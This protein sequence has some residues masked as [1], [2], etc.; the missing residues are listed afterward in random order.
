MTVK[1][2]L[3]VVDAP[4]EAASSAATSM[5]DAL[6]AMIKTAI[7]AGN[8]DAIQ[9]LVALQ[10]EQ[11][12]ISREHDENDR[13]EQR[14]IAFVQAL[15][16]AQSKFKVI[17]KDTAVEFDGR[18]STVQFDYDS[19]E[20]IAGAIGDALREEGFVLSFEPEVQ[21]VAGNAKISVTA[22]LEHA[23]G[24][25]RRIALPG[26]P[27]AKLMGNQMVFGAITALKRQLTR[28]ITGATLGSKSEELK[29]NE[30]RKKN[31]QAGSY[32]AIDRAD[33]IS[34]DQ[35][36]DL[37]LLLKNSKTPETLFL[38]K[39]KKRDWRDIAKNEFDQIRTK[40]V[41]WLEKRS[42]AIK[43]KQAETEQKENA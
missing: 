34:D 41:A 17:E 10:R 43:A 15:A 16:R 19:E 9:A 42:A 27:D 11:I 20:A 36:N 40:T 33:S 38:N 8:V 21:G 13:A 7:E 32:Q 23:E 25:V 37:K 26:M 31:D 28:M 22:I 24:H 4:V 2:S 3:T 6:P 39:I 5:I 18:K 35:I 12:E 14:R 1:K 30:E 29:M